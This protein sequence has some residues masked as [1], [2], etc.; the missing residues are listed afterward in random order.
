VSATRIR[1]PAKVNLCL[2]VGPL[3]R[4]GYHRVTTLVQAIDLYD[5]LELSEADEIA[6]ECFDDT[7]VRHALEALGER[8]RVRLGKRIPVAGGLGGGSSDAAAVLR[9]VGSG[10]S[11]DE[12]H[13]IARTIGT[14]V[15]FFLSGAEAALASGRGDRIQPL[16]DFP[17]GHAFVL[18]PDARGLSTGTV[19][20]ACEP[21]DIFLAVQGELFRRAH[22]ARQPEQVAALMANDLESA[23][24]ALRPEVAERLAALR[25]AGALRAMVSGSGPTAFGLFSDREAA[26]RA[27]ETIPGAIAASPVVPGAVAASPL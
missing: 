26:E 27:A 2:R 12:L 18:V 11:P 22:T 21:N 10:R 6:V 20:A 9:A 19:Y 15:P 17:R 13:A 14:D 5:E 16:P 23:V 7:L 8:R 4:D 25:G 24:L 3:R 1:T